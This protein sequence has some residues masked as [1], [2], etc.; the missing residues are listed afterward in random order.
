MAKQSNI[1]RAIRDL[2]VAGWTNREIADVLD[3]SDRYVRMIRARIQYKA[4]ADENRQM[5]EAAAV[6]LRSRMRDRIRLVNGG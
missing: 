2:A 1:P 6:A 5:I 3:V 4:Q